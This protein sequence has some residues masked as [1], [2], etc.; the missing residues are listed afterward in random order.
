MCVIVYKPA[1]ISVGM[2]ILRRCWERNSDGAGIMFP[3]DG[4]LI[5]A[6]G[7]MAWRPFKK[8]VKRMGDNTLCNTPIAFHFRIATHGSIGPDNCHPFT[9]NDNIAMMHNGIMSNVNIDDGSDKSDSEAFVEQ[10]VSAFSNIMIS[11]LREGTALNDLYKA[12]I[13]SS[14]LLFMDS[15]GDVAI[16]N[17]HLGYD[18]KGVGQEG[19]WFSNR[20]WQPT[21][22]VNYGGAGYTPNRSGFLTGYTPSRSG[23]LSGNKPVN[24]YPRGNGILSPLPDEMYEDDTSPDQLMYCR[25]CY[26]SFKYKDVNVLRWDGGYKFVDCPDCGSDDTIEDVFGDY[27]QWDDDWLICHDCGSEF[28]K[29]SSEPVEYNGEERFPCPTCRSYN[30]YTDDMAKVVEEHGDAFFNAEVLDTSK[31]NGL[32]DNK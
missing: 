11:N 26:A 14:K 25:G 8:Y 9:V 6:K 31:Y 1:G 2:D 12:Y 29:D 20:T 19:V 7:F 30:T 21:T 32:G 18:G 23:F 22:V 27:I 10:Y 16:V 3:R 24:M 28:L 4:K 17:R 13:K 5:V 15:E